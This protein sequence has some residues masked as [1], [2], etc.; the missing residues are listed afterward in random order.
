MG[1]GRGHLALFTLEEGMAIIQWFGN[2]K[3]GLKLS[4]F[5]QVMTIHIRDLGCSFQASRG[6]FELFLVGVEELK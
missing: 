2:E 4:G 1:L 5:C 3:F 6:W